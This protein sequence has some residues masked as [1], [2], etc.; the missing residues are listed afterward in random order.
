MESSY[1]IIEVATTRCTATAKS[2]GQQCGKPAIPGGTVCRLHG[3]SAPQVRSKAADRLEHARNLALERLIEQLGPPE[4]PMYAVEVKDLLAVVD[5]LTSKVQLL[6][7][8]AT[9][10]D[11]S[12]RVDV[13]KRQLELRLDQLGERLGDRTEFL[14]GIQEAEVIDE[15]T[16]S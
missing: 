4:S 6:R 3:G 9:S 5:K 10:R 1:E 14:E 15:S 13:V 11:E 2:S 16:D 7:G 8:E 12:K